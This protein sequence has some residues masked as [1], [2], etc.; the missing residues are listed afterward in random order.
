MVMTAVLVAVSIAM[1][2]R[3]WVQVE[4]IPAKLLVVAVEVEDLELVEQTGGLVTGEPVALH[5][6]AQHYYHFVED[7]VGVAVLGQ[8][9]LGVAEVGQF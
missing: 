4:E 7:L 6:G 3:D 9:S 1:V 2:A 5:M 8:T